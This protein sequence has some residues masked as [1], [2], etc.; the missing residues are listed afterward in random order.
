MEVGDAGNYM[1][2]GGA[3]SW[4]PHYSAASSIPSP[5]PSPLDGEGKFDREIPAIKDLTVPYA[6]ISRLDY[7]SGF[8]ALSF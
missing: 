8:Y 3:A 4:M 6:I 1:R 7:I 5:G 2:N